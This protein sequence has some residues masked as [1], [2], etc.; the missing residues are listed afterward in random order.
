MIVQFLGAARTVTGSCH[1]LETPSGRL[2]LD[3]GMYQ[4]SA[5]LERRNSGTYWPDPTTLNYVLLSHAHIDH[6]GLIP[7]LV[8]QGFRGRILAT[9]A[10]IDLA[11]I[12]LADSAHIQEEDAKYLR[13]RWAKHGHPGEPPEPLYTA[14]EA[15]HAMR[16]F[17]PVPYNEIIELDSRL[18]VR[19]HDAGHILGSAAIEVIVQEDQGERVLVFSGDLGTPNRPLLRNPSTLERAD[20]L[21]TES[22][23]GYRFH[24]PPEERSE[25]FLAII[26]ETADRGGRLI[27]PSFSVGRTQDLL[28]EINNFVEGGMLKPLPVYVDSPLA[29]SATKI[30]EAH[31]ECFDAATH[32][33]LTKGDDPF[34]FPGLQFTRTV[35]ESKQINELPGPCI[36]ISASGMCTAGRIRHHLKHALPQAKNTVLFV[37]FQAR[38]TLGRRLREGENP[39]RIFGRE[40]PVAATIRTMNAFSAHAD[41]PGLLDWF[42][43]FQPPPTFTACVHGEELAAFELATKIETQYKARTYVPHWQEEVDLGD[44]ASLRRLAVEQRWDIEWDFD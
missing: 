8:S 13:K 9:S 15:E 40:V 30:F 16:V 28:Y 33:L 20:Y 2:L 7:R 23:Y 38:G 43:H 32:E 12:L 42:A 22:T 14:A 19:F 21:L 31:P 3:C 44:E 35:E 34:E 36:I 29:I 41:Q 1:L 37:G 11:K 10:T 39:V 24:E 26:H 5:S 27:I 4:G 6:C 25:K 18:A 17:R